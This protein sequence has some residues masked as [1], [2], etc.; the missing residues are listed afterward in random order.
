VDT[1]VVRLE[2][3]KDLLGGLVTES[4]ATHIGEESKFERERVRN[5]NWELV[6]QCA[7]KTA[8]L[9]E[10]LA[11][12]GTTDHYAVLWFPLDPPSKPDGSSVGSI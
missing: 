6:R 1:I 10:P 2:L 8:L 4:R 12:A 11:I 3:H 9:F 5:R 7:D